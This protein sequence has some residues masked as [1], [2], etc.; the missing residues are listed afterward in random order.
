[1]IKGTD[2]IKRYSQ[3]DGMLVEN[4]KGGW[5]QFAELEGTEQEIKTWMRRFAKHAD[6]PQ[7]K[8]RV[9][10]ICTCGL[11]KFIKP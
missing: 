8:T 5:I 6:F 1:M 10:G 3:K 4:E 2:V 7:C 9:T 11:D